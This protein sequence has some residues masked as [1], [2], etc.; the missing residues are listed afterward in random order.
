MTPLEAVEKIECLRYLE[1]GIPLKMVLTE[2]KGVGI[3]TPDDLVRAK[4]LLD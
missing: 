3:D 1:H 2:F 4:Q